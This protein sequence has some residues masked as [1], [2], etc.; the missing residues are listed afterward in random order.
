MLTLVGIGISKIMH[1]NGESAKSTCRIG[2]LGGLQQPFLS[3]SCVWGMTN[4]G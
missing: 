4:P 1:V 2:I 3:S